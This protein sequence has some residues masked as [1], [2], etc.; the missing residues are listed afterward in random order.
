MN[1]KKRKSKKSFEKEYF[2]VA[3]PIV[4]GIVAVILIFNWIDRNIGID[5]FFSYLFIYIITSTAIC[6]KY[7]ENH[8]DK[9]GVDGLLK[10]YEKKFVE[11]TGKEF[12]DEKL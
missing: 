2:T 4:L 9:L 11:L 6:Y 10:L 5:R 1:G 12:K 8:Y 3:L 7:I